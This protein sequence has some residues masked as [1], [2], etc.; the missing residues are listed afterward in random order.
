MEGALLVAFLLPFIGLVIW[1]C[2]TR[3]EERG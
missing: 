1:R 2:K 3:N